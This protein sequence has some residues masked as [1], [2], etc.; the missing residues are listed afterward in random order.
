MLSTIT[1]C[2]PITT[3][4]KT[5]IVNSSILMGLMVHVINLVCV[6]SEEE[7]SKVGNN[8]N[9][10]VGKS[11][12]LKA[13]GK[14]LSRADYICYGR[15]QQCIYGLLPQALVFRS[16]RETLLSLKNKHR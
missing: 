13:I 8:K 4:H 15:R 9:K 7:N 3:F 1:Q 12:V 11:Y 2:F 16:S 14:V 10:Y 5:P 6:Y